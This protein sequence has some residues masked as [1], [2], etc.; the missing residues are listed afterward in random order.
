MTALKKF[1]RLE[2]PGIWRPTREA[3]RQD[4]IVS[5]GEASLVIADRNEKALSHWS[6]AAVVRIN[7]GER[8]ALYTP[9]ADT[10][11]T[12]E[13]DDETMI[14][15]IETIRG[16]I[17]RA[18]PHRG[19]LRLVLF[20]TA[21][22]MLLA[23]AAFWLPGMLVRHTLGVV[24]DP[25]RAEIGTKL[26]QAI[27]R[28]TGSPCRSR[29][30]DQALARLQARLLPPGRGALLV[31]PDGLSGTISLPGGVMLLGRQLVEG[32]EV[33][34]VTAGHILAEAE[35]QARSDPLQAVL[36]GA[37]PLAT[38]R[39]LTTGHIKD[40]TLQAYAETLTAQEPAPVPDAALLER[41]AAA[42]ISSTPYAYALDI[43]GEST[44]GLIEADPMRS[45]G[46]RR[47]VLDDSDWVAL[48]GICGH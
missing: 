22:G 28:V 40:E 13:I 5:F 21:V 30:G 39:L 14:E 17:L 48:Q 20:T 43:T 6:L 16:A 23:A 18:R 10:T 37:G 44:F 27:G 46:A 24:P 25:T 9:S 26:F 8:P 4:V 1:S 15:A 29:R 36:Q 34:E 31:V 32:P 45:T 12:L 2:A 3:Q 38:L 47:P 7:R 33:P 11:E 41:F 19:R 42:G 35:R